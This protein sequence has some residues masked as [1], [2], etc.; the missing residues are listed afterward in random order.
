MLE[1]GDSQPVCLV[2]DQQRAGCL[3]TAVIFGR[4][5]EACK[6]EPGMSKAE[7]IYLQPIVDDLRR[8]GDRRGEEETPAGL[9]GAGRLRG[10][11]LADG[12]FEE[13]GASGE[14]ARRAR[15]SN[16]RSAKAHADVALGCAG[17]GEFPEARVLAGFN[18]GQLPPD[19][20]RR[21]R[22]A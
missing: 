17:L 3:G 2:H 15:L 18:E 14:L 19:L 12:V 16:P 6:D 13:I 5:A 11:R 1:R 21:R 4:F 10:D 20:N 9:H 8:V 7:E 22:R